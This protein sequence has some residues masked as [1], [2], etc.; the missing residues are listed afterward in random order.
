MNFDWI[1]TSPEWEACINAAGELTGAQRMV[2][3]A[4]VFFERSDIPGGLRGGFDW[5][6]A[7]QTWAHEQ[8]RGYQCYGR[9]DGRLEFLRVTTRE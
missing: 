3:R 7:W 8:H 1:E 9:H 5:R 4:D 2:L 6:P